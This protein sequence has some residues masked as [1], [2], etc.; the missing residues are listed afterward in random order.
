MIF[1][2]RILRLFKITL[3]VIKLLIIFTIL[4]VVYNVLK[5]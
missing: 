1:F 3:Y 2:L 4:T 5:F